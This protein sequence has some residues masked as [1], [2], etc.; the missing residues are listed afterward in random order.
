MKISDYSENELQNIL[1]SIKNVDK[2]AMK[3]A[4]ERQ[5]KLAKPPRSL[6]RLEDLSV[7][8]AGI[9]GKVKNK[10]NNKN[11]INNN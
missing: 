10:F 11:N 4:R 5:D 1:H 3:S 9:T 6:G 8:L 7:Q 2:E